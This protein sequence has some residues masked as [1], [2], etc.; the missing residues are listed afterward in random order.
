MT[1][2][3][4]GA[5][6]PETPSRVNRAY[7]TAWR[8]H[9]YAGLY[10]IP[11]LA[12]LAITGILM[13]WFTAI[14]P[15][16]G[17]RIAV[18]PT[19]A[20]QS[21]TAQ[22]VAAEAAHPGSHAV[23]YIA[24]YDAQTPAIV[25]VQDG[26][27][28]RMLAIDPYSGAVMADRPEAG[29]W[30]EWLTN[31]HGEILWGGNG[32]PGDALIEIAASLGMVMLVTGLYLSWPR[33]GASWRS[34]FVPDLAARGRKFWKSL[35]LTTGVWMSLMLVF[36]L[37]TGL[38]WAGIWGGKLVQPWSSFPAAKWDA[39]PLSDET[40][41]AMNHTAREEVPWTLELTPLPESGSQTGVQLLPH[42]TPVTFETVMAGA[43]A[44]GFDARVQVSAPADGKGVWTLSRDSMSYDSPVPTDDRT[45]HID[46]YTGKV[47]ADVRFADYPA[48]GKAMAVGIAAHEGQMGLWNVVLNFVV[49]GAFLLTCVAGVVLWWKRRPVAAGRLAAP[50]QGPEG[51]LW[52]GG[53]I[54]AVIVALAFPMGG[55]AILAVL[56]LDALVLKRLPGLKRMLS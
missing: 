3:T 6:P 29:T 9:F 53:L 33:G 26:D 54:V 34:V 18:T 12:M 30:N 41:A 4:S 40:H 8:W 1:D 31:L 55:A 24:P 21:V 15:E 49:C 45:V 50:P 38:S 28:A 2:T 27:T 17:D 52:K 19:A 20:A 22:I 25:R 7:F 35:H 56:A 14:A 13:I 47:L 16:Y 39:V 5:T 46:Q 37:L 23:K 42:G 10:V 48:M 32:G 51:G 43:R 36:F 11:F 44:L